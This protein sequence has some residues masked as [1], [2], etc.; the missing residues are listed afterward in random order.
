MTDN[1]IILLNEKSYL[2]QLLYLLGI[3]GGCF[4]LAQAITVVMMLAAGYDLESLQNLDLTNLAPSEILLY[5][6]MQIISSILLFVV[7][8]LIWGYLKSKPGS[9]PS[10]WDTYLL[11][12]EGSESSI[13]AN[14][15]WSY[16]KLRGPLKITA[17]L[18]AILVTVGSLAF[19]GFTKQINDMLVLPE[20]LSG[21]EEMMRTMEDEGEKLIMMFLEVNGIGGL[22]LNI[23]MIA[24]IPAIG[25]ELLFRGALQQLVQ[26]WT[27]K[28]HL[29]IWLTA[30]LFSFF[31]FQFYGFL[32]RMFLGAMF[33]YL[34]YWSGSLWY[35]IIG[36][37]MNNGFQVVGYYVAQSMGM[38]DGGLDVDATIPIPAVLI[39]L[40]I[41]VV[42]SIIFYK[43]FNREERPLLEV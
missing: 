34:F 1:S 13:N 30:A 21:L 38:T 18:I 41:L 26:E 19:M 32:P 16:L 10:N 31:H 6:W 9:K 35:P 12:K 11:E 14:G 22:L 5:K 28:P 15:K 40:A 23:L 43:Q 2:T 3:F 4:M 8:A 25:E 36:H 39:S 17:V 33:G 27:K 7:P 37:F 42:G 29:A 24:I 20:F